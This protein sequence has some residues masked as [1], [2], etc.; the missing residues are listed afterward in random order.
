MSTVLGHLGRSGGCDITSSDDEDEGLG[1]PGVALTPMLPLGGTAVSLYWLV[2][3]MAGA[4]I[5]VLVG[6]IFI[7]STALRHLGWTWVPSCGIFHWFV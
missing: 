6:K 4:N 7:T 1:V 5:V 2:S 3:T